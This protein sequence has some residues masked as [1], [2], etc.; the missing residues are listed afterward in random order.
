[1][2]VLKQGGNMKIKLTQDF[3]FLHKR[4]I[5]GCS[6]DKVQNLYVI[7]DTTGFRQSLKQKE[8]EQ[9][10]K[11]SIVV[12]KPGESAKSLPDER[13][14]VEQPGTFDAEKRIQQLKQMPKAKLKEMA[15]KFGDIDG[16]NSKED[17]INIIVEA[18]SKV[19]KTI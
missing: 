5:S 9:L 2:V 3:D 15:L 16:F 7:S 18:E 19:K 8:Y 17:L 11:A 14:R 6:V 4:G 13:S 12:D 10:M 1:M